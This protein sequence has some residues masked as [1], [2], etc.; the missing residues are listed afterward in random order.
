MSQQSMTS[1]FAAANVAAAARGEYSSGGF[2]HRHAAA[3]RRALS[4]ALGVCVFIIVVWSA[5]LAKTSTYALPLAAI[6]VESLA[7]A[8]T[9]K[10]D[11][12]AARPSAEKPLTAP[13]VGKPLATATPA[14]LT[15]ETRWFNGRPVRPARSIWIKATGY[16]PDERSCGDSADGLT[17]TLH[18][19][20]TN[21]FRLVAADPTVLPYGSMVTI[22]GYD[23]GEIVPVL[24]CGGAIKGHRLDLLFRTHAEARYWGVKSLP[25]VVWEYADGKPADNPRKLR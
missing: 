21:A 23:N 14:K 20:E 18:S 10:W 8:E 25:V 9:G 6:R 13:T 3:L 19:V 17:A 1:P 11:V 24:D 12:P 2:S 5:I 16:S 22:P 7:K 15:E 4:T